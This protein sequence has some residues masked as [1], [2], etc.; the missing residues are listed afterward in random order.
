MAEST[1][2]GKAGDFFVTLVDFFAIL[3]PGALLAFLIYTSLRRWGQL[4]NVAIPEGWVGFTAIGLL[5]YL[6]GHFL[7]VIGSLCLDSVYDRWKNTWRVW[8]PGH[9]PGRIATWIRAKPKIRLLVGGARRLGQE[10]WRSLK[11]V[12]TERR[13]ARRALVLSE[14]PGLA[15]AA[16]ALRIATSGGAAEMDHLEA[17]QKLFRGLILVFLF[18]WLTFFWDWKWNSYWPWVGV[19]LLLVPVIPF[20]I[21]KDIP[22]KKAEDEKRKIATAQLWAVMVLFLGWIV[23]F[24][25][26]P[27]MCAWPRSITEGV[28]TENSE[29]SV[30]ASAG[31]A[32]G[33]VSVTA[34][35]EN[36]AN[37]DVLWN[38]RASHP[39][40]FA[41]VLMF[42]LALSVL[43][44]VQQRVKYSKF[45]Y[46]AYRILQSARPQG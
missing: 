10:M 33:N 9:P 13:E 1:S 8:E 46:R 43:R 26:T 20:W 40:T 42:V 14:E 36:D 25:T 18:A 17:D 45:V 6:L 24:A 15:E 32:S 7:F 4:T 2:G 19:M 28:K 5:S 16:V 30:T 3:L 38:L 37:R 39:T 41:N 34:K 23:W 31:N 44:F 27:R 35:S 11:E 29:I 22:A 21:P 12:N